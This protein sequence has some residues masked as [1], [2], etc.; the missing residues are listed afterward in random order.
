M[1]GQKKARVGCRAGVVA[2]AHQV[3]AKEL[4]RSFSWHLEDMKEHS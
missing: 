1:E 2:R 3:K 4:E